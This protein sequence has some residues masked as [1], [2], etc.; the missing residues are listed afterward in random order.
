MPKISAKFQ[1]DHPNSGA[2]YKWGTLK[3]AVLDQYVAI[4]YFRTG[5]R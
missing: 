5:A 3:S 2:K 4:A 1:W